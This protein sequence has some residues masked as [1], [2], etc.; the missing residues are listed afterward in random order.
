MSNELRTD[1]TAAE[2]N[3]IIQGLRDEYGDREFSDELVLLECQDL[4]RKGCHNL[5]H[6]DDCRG[7]GKTGYDVGSNCSL[8][9]W[10]KRHPEYKDDALAKRLK[11]LRDEVAGVQR[12]DITKRLLEKGYI[13]VQWSQWNDGELIK[14]DVKLYQPG[15][16]DLKADLMD[17]VENWKNMWGEDF[18]L[19]YIKLDA[20]DGKIMDLRTEYGDEYEI[21]EVVE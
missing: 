1:F 9:D 12:E 6:C 17:A 15:S 3:T 20:T 16:K 18:M 13:K 5:E 4:W 2:R 10:E 11:E 21:W 14:S 8:L 7:C 19:P